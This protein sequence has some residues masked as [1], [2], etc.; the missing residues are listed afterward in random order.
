MFLGESPLFILD[1]IG[2]AVFAISGALAAGRKSLDWF[3]VMVI[4]V[5]TA[6]GGGTLRD[7]LLDQH[8]IFWIADPGYLVVICSTALFTLIYIRQ[9]KWHGKVTVTLGPR[10][11]T[12]GKALLI[13]DAL[14]LALF[15]IT[16]TQIA[17]S[18]Q[19]HPIIAVVMGTMT[20]VAGGVIRDVL[21]NDVPLILQRDIYASAALAGS[22]VYLIIQFLGGSISLAMGMGMTVVVVLRMMAI[23]WGLRLPV[24]RLPQ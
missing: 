17:E 2:V 18:H 24:F 3:G 15:C 14:G 21:S 5:V 4:A 11:I 12:P 23:L 19:L 16:G 1:L 9:P 8:P 7:I 20:G 6:I 22:T 10:K 13:A